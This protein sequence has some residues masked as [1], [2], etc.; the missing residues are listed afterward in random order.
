MKPWHYWKL[1]LGAAAA[2]AGT[3]AGAGT[4]SAELAREIAR[5]APDD[6][7]PVIIRLA[8]RVDMLPFQIKDRRQRHNGLMRALRAKSALTLPRLNGLLDQSGAGARK[9]LWINNAIAVTVP[10]RAIAALARHGAVDRVQYDAVVTFAAPATKAASISAAGAPWNLNAIHV[11]EVWSLGALGAGVVVANMDTG[12]DAAHPDLQS[13]WRG[14]AN[15]WYDPNQ[16]HLTP[17][18]A[19]GHGTQTM[20]LIVGG[21]ASGAPIG[22]APNAKWIAAKIFNDAGQAT[23]SNIHLAFQWLLDP[24]GDPATLDAPDVVNASWGLAGGALGACNMEF[25]ADIQALAAAGIVVIFAAG[26]DGPVAASSA[27]PA[28]NPAAFSVGALD[29]S[30]AVLS[31]SS[32]G[33]SGCDGS[34]FPKVAAPGQNVVS[35]DLSFGGL[36]LFANVTGTSFAAPHV[37]GAMALLASAFPAASVTQL[38][39]AV[40]DSA[41]D[42]DLTGADNNS[43]YGVLNTLAAHHVLANGNGGQNTPVITSLP[44]TEAAE[45]QQYRYQLSATDADG[46]VLRFALAAGPAGMTMDTTTGLLSWTPAHAQ[47]GANA[48]TISVTDPT[49]RAATQTW[50]VLVASVNSA[51]VAIADAYSTAAGS[52]LNVAAPGV[53]ANDQ[54]AQG[55]VMAAQLASAPAHGVLTLAADGSF[56]FVP[57]AGYAGTDSFSYRASDGKLAGNLATVTINVVAPPP[58]PPVARNDAFS[59]PVYRTNPYAARRL[60]VLANDSA[61]AGTIA[62]SSVVLASSPN[63]GGRVTVNSDGTLSYTPALRYSGTETFSYKFRNSGNAWSNTATVSVAVH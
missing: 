11:P 26:N 21:A 48:V 4:I 51:P 40:M 46:G 59:A 60:A 34:I 33:P 56:R 63:K 16:Q 53:L 41:A 54:D 18:D 38:K 1:L 35:S 62:A 24:D 57:A 36:P 29:A 27:S 23:L 49:G 14:G 13:S 43:G 44:A 32:R 52:A 5:H 7:I 15:S 2:C 50:S 37:S 47:V 25:N 20:G 12:V 22:V 19:S 45:N 61:G 31:Q 3:A 17:Y 10:V 9:T 58:A 6:R 8:E 42:I 30:L 28:A 39:N 55:D